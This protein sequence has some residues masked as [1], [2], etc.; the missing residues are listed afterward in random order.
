MLRTTIHPL[1]ILP[2]NLPPQNLMLRPALCKRDQ[3]KSTGLDPDIGRRHVFHGKG[4][5]SL[6][7]IA[8]RRIRMGLHLRGLANAILSD[9]VIRGL[10]IPMDPRSAISVL[11]V[12]LETF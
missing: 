3:R 6:R 7:G 9:G 11:S 5:R 10:I 8:G 12:N 2:L 4:R 1:E